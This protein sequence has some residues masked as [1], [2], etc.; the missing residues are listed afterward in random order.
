MIPWLWQKLVGNRRDPEEAVDY[1]PLTPPDD[2]VAAD[3]VFYDAA[4]RFLDVQISTNDV[5]DTRT[6][7]AFSIGSTVLPVTFGLLRLSTVTIPTITVILLALAL[8]MYVALLFCV[9]RA[10]RLRELQYRPN[11]LTLE[12]NSEVA[13]GQVLRRWVA[14]EYVVS[15]EINKPLLQRKGLWVGR[16]VTALYAE[17]LFLSAA[18]IA[19]LF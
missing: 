1:W 4:S 2:A 8:A 7:N 11:L 13:P 19:T 12:D 14:S 17:G 6:S 10:S 9:W 3:E 18:A 5:F 15:T 16:A